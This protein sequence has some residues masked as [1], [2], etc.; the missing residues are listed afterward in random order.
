MYSGVLRQLIAD[1]PA[2]MSFFLQ[3][4]A[5]VVGHRNGWQSA[6]RGQFIHPKVAIWQSRLDVC[7]SSWMSQTH[8][9]AIC[10]FSFV[11]YNKW[12]CNKESEFGTLVADYYRLTNESRRHPSPTDYEW[13]AKRDWAPDYCG[14]FSF[15]RRRYDE[16]DD[17][18][19]TSWFRCCGCSPYSFMD[20]MW[21][22]APLVL[23]TDI[24]TTSTY[25]LVAASI[26][27]RAFLLPI[28]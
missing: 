5:S 17:N 24:C 13:G 27:F 1:K 16:G 15:R 22:R 7:V 8:I 26:F 11:S 4:R 6:A 25:P 9:V 28:S 23:T 19:L 3:K 14:R 21:F 10:V 18:G 20:L 12:W 2:S